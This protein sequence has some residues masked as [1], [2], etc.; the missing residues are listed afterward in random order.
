MMGKNHVLI[1]GLTGVSLL[2]VFGSLYTKRNDGFL[3]E[4]TYQ[5]FSYFYPESVKFFH[6]GFSDHTI[7]YLFFS[8][9]FFWFGTLLPDIDSK[10]SILGSCLYVPVKHR[11]WT[12][13]IWALIIV[14]F[15]G[16]LHPWF[17]LMPVG[18]GLHLLC[19]QFSA[20]GLC[21]FYPFKKY[22]VYDTGAFVAPGHT[23]KLYHTG[24]L[25]EKHFVLIVSGIL[26]LLILYAGLYKNGLQMFFKWIVY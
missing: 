24:R 14:S 19:D 4:I 16:L 18:F 5:V 3:Y 2:S 11:T 12:H 9:L 20:S 22:I 25:S 6:M 13:S 21:F 15:V 7:V 10:S 1:N 17:R 8:T 23:W 26:L